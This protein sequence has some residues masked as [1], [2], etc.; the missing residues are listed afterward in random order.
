MTD[1]TKELQDQPKPEDLDA[2][3]REKLPSHFRNVA[4]RHGKD[5]F[6]L[7]FIAGTI[8]EGLQ[9]IGAAGRGHPVIMQGVQIIQHQ[10]D[11]L[12]QRAIAL[13]G[14]EIKDFAECRMDCERA[15]AL[16]GPAQMP[17]AGQR[18]S[19]GGIIIDS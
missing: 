4:E 2:A 11:M 12:C 17:Q 15:A 9:R 1:E 10:A 18:T 6:E 8:G 16:A 14:K 3:W 13:L 19:P 7:V 5:M